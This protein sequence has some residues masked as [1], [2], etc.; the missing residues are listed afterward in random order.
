MMMFDIFTPVCLLAVPLPWEDV[1]S[2]MVI[3]SAY[4]NS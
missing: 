2:L 1:A 3:V 4:L